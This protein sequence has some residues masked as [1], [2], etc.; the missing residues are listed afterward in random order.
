MA[1]SCRVCV[2]PLHAEF[3]RLRVT[4]RGI[5]D[6]HAA[7]EQTAQAERHSVSGQ[8]R[9]QVTRAMTQAQ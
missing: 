5:C 8:I 6:P 3:V 4:A 7:I 2:A 1:P 9:H